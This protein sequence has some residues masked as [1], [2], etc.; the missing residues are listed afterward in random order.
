M[1]SGPAETV[2]RA[3]QLRREMTWPEVILWRRLRQ[4]PDGFKFRRQHP[5]GPYVLDFFCASAGL[6]I[7]VDGFTHNLG[8]RPERDRERDDWLARRGVRALRI[9]ASDLTRDPDGAVEMIVAACKALAPP[10]ASGR[11]PPR[12]RGGDASPLANDSHYRV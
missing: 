4:R 7:E 8:G 2:K 6:A 1:L 10:P 5:A 12:S 3:R 11:S 9:G